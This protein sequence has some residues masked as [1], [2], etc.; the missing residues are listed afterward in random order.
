VKWRA[1]IAIVN[2]VLGAALVGVQWLPQALGFG[3]DDGTRLSLGLLLFPAAGFAIG[4]W[5]PGAP[6]AAAIGVFV[7]WQVPALVLEAGATGKS[8]ALGFGLLCALL[9]AIGEGF[10]SGSRTRVSGGNHGGVR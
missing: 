7:G 4:R 10:G 9:E 1:P 3:P 2:V 6:L 8:L 5:L